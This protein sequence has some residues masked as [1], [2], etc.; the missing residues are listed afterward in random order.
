MTHEHKEEALVVSG[1]GSTLTPA[2]VSDMDAIQQNLEA[3]RAFVQRN[4]VPGEDYGIIEGVSEKPVLLQPGAQKL[5]MYHGYAWELTCTAEE[6]DRETGWVR[7]VYSGKAI[8]RRNGDIVV[9]GVDGEAHSYEDRYYWRWL[10]LA[11]M[12]PRQKV[13]KDEFVSRVRRIGNKQV[14]QWRVPADPVTLIGLANTIRKIAQKRCLVSLA[15]HACRA[16]GIFTVDLEDL[17]PEARAALSVG[18]GSGRSGPTP[19]SGKQRSLIQHLANSAGVDAV[20]VN[21]W[22]K[23]HLGTEYCK[24]LTEKERDK[25]RQKGYI[26]TPDGVYGFV[27]TS[28]QASR[29]IDALKQG[30]VQPLGPPEEE[31][32]PAPATEAPTGPPVEEEVIEAEPVQTEPV[33]VDEPEAE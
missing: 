1:S 28:K 24:R 10:T 2:L 17:S 9:S 18:S 26:V 25:L 19:M 13:H 31:Q 4:M 22:C 23:Q 21:A 6:M 14:Q 11:Q 8:S 12:T 32:Q 7:F 3:L 16:S 29:L 5:L 30:E 15:A 27:L 33:E 20:S